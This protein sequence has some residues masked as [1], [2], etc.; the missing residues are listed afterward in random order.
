MSDVRS[1]RCVTDAWLDGGPGAAAIGRNVD[2]VLDAVRTHL[3]MDVA[4]VTEFNGRDRIFRHVTS[5]LAACPIRPGDMRPQD[6]GYCRRVV[7]GAIPQ[8]IPD[9]TAFPVLLDIAETTAIP[10]GAHLSVPIRLRDGRVYG[11][12][13]CFSLEPN[14]ALG[15][16]DLRMMH[17]FADLLA[18]QIDG[19]LDDM[20]AHRETVERITAVLDMGQPRVL[21]Q[22]V[23]RCSERRMVGV[24]C[25]ARFDLPPQRPPDAWFAEAHG[26]GLGVRL[27]LNAILYAIDGLRGIEGDFHVGLNVSP[28]TILWGGIE[29]YLDGVDPHRVVLEIT[30]HAVVADYPLL[31]D[32]LAGLR[33]AGVRIAVDDVGAGYASMRHVLALRPDIVKL[34]LSL[35]RGI[36]GDA[37]RRALAAAL[38]AFAAQMGV[39]VIAEGVETA[40]E[41]AT[42]HGIGVDDVQG[43]HLSAPVPAAQVAAALGAG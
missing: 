15:R 35:T 5:R 29:D 10:I 36:D 39:A 41:L 7:D 21:Y 2:R 20:L 14:P 16:R 24:E 32:H 43:H 3:G 22:P 9:T 19:D 8:L 31:N 30:E 37:P 42:L 38:V 25:L 34:D 12:F 26:I 6:E 4:F 33:R 23:Y 18:C 28:Q 1:N 13:C 11:T 17:A 27:E 40:A